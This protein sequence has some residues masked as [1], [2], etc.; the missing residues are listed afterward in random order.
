MAVAW[1]ATDFQIG[2]G[3]LLRRLAAALHLTRTGR[4]ILTAIAVTWLPIMVLG[5]LN[6]S[7]G[8]H[9]EPLLHQ[10]VMYVRLLVAAPVLLASDAI[11]PRTSSV[12]LSQ[13]VHDSF[14]PA[15][16]EPRFQRLL[17]QGARLADSWLPETVLVL[18]TLSL[19]VGALVGIGAG[20]PRARP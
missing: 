19:A 13:L 10:A 16:A 7:L 17:R 20:E 8:G 5:L 3:G 6:E 1:T 9:R 18:V 4:Q 15:D 2:G 12:V 11:L 14:I